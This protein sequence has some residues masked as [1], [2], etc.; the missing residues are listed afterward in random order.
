M[1]RLTNLRISLAWQRLSWRAPEWWIA[2]GIFCAWILILARPL[3]PPA[4]AVHVHHQLAAAHERDLLGAVASMTV[5]ML[6][7]ALPALRRVALASLWHRRQL[8]MGGFLIGYVA[9]CSALS[10]ALAFVFDPLSALVDPLVTTAL[11]LVLGISWQRTTTKRRAVRRCHAMGA[12]AVSGWEADRDCV[13]VGAALASNCLLGCWPLMLVV[14]A[15]GHHP[16]VM[17]GGL[18]AML[19]DLFG[20]YVLGDA[21]AAVANELRFAWSTPSLGK[22]V[23]ASGILGRAGPGPLALGRKPRWSCLW[24]LSSPRRRDAPARAIAAGD[25]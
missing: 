21:A 14:A 2:A 23:L 7:A 4:A 24:R 11:S 3:L 22:R 17:L 9:I 19:V 15:A 16:V 6:P 8:A 1:A 20:R 25:S 5:M 10:A 12:L 13:R 18:A